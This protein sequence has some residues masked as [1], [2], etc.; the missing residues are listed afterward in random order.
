M[1]TGRL[2]IIS[3]LLF[4]LFVLCCVANQK[5]KRQVE[6]NRLQLYRSSFD[7]DGTICQM[8]LRSRSW[9]FCLLG[10]FR[11]GLVSAAAGGSFVYLELG[12]EK[13]EAKSVWKRPTSLSSLSCFRNN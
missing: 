8:K 6:S 1:E 5:K 4:Q 11:F 13:S 10:R 9:S 12:Q 3:I 2:V 7:V